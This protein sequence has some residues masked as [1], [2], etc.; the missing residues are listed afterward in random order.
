MNWVKNDNRDLYIFEI[1]LYKSTKNDIPY[2][3]INDDV[4]NKIY[5]QYKKLAKNTIL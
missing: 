2:Y 5:N 1:L 3:P 4:N